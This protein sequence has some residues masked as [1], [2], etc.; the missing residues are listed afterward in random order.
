MKEAKIK[1]YWKSAK[2][3]L[4]T[5]MIQDK[6]NMENLKNELCTFIFNYCANYVHIKLSYLKFL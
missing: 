6:K 5:L 1:S 2:M 4:T 3:S